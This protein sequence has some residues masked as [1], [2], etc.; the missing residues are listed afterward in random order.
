MYYFYLLS[1]SEA[2]IMKGAVQTT[3]KLSS[4]ACLI[5]S[6]RQSL[7]HKMSGLQVYTIGAHLVYTS[8]VTRDMC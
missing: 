4:T 5:Y 6:C 2:N 1:H 8:A 7:I 3:L